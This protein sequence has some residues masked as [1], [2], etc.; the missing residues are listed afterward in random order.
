MTI[1]AERSV[2]HI[3]QFNEGNA[4]MNDLLGGKGSNLCEMSQ[5][6]LPVPPGFVITTQVC[7]DYLNENQTLPLDL[8]VSIQDNI[9]A[10]GKI[11]R[12]EFWVY[13][14]PSFGVSTLWSPCFHAGDDGYHIKFGDQRPNCRRISVHN[15]RPKA[16]LRRIPALHPDLFRS[17]DGCRPRIL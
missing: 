13:L 10:S 16:R 14:K 6:G 15:G 9:K 11:H 2:K 12:S 8:E 3:Y 17:G 5:L 1:H 7:R 4:S